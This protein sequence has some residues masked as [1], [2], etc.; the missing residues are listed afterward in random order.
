MAA[1][2]SAM[3]L[4]AFGILPTRDYPMRE[5][6]DSTHMMRQAYER[7]VVLEMYDPDKLIGEIQ[8]LLYERGLNPDLPP[9]TGRVGMAAGASGMLLRAFG[10]L[11][12]GDY[13][14]IDRLNAPDPDS[15]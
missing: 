11:P 6:M 9:R 12:A 8:D 2:A 7:G 13:T 15:R 5:D 14:T 3:L 4:R 10:I 1:G